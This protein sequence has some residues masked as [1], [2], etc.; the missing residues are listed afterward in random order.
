[1][2]SGALTAGMRGTPPPSYDQP[3]Q[4]LGL[5]QPAFTSKAMQQTSQKYI[6]QTQSLFSTPQRPGSQGGYNSGSQSRPGTR[7]NDMPRATSPLPQRSVSPRPGT[8]AESR[9]SYR[10]ASPNPYAGSQQRARPQPSSIQKRGSDQTYRQNSYNDVARA[11]SPAPF[12]DHSDRPGSGHRNSDMS[13]QLAP[14]P[15][16][17]YGGSQRGRGGGNGRPGTSGAARPM[18]YYGG[19]GEQQQ[20][21]QAAAR[22][23]SKSVADG[24]QFTRDGRPILHF[25]RCHEQG[26]LRKYC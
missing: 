1:M 2:A 21:V 9:Q 19:H 8:Q 20:Q 25:G 17:G 11:I 10:S 7:G 24:R 13:I 23:R 12:R 5:P 26:V 3:M 6:S 16:D 22:Q 4:R 15:D 18:S 14:S